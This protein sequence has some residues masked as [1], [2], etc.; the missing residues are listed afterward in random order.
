GPATGQLRMTPSELRRGKS[1]VFVGIDL[2]G[3]DGLATRATFCFG[4]A[5]ASTLSHAALGAPK[6]DAPDTCLNFFDRAP[7]TLH[8]L[9]HID[10]RLAGGQLPFS[11]ADDPTML[12]WLRHRDPTL[13]P[14]LV[15]LLALADAPPPAAL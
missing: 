10:G 7:R 4:S 6:A 9:Q 15:S 11:G 5:R 1:T 13:K 12:L 14:T 2:S 8:F 3:E